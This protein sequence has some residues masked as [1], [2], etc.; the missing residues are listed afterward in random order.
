MSYFVESSSTAMS[1]PL[2]STIFRGGVRENLDKLK[3]NRVD[4]YCSNGMLSM[5]TGGLMPC[6]I[7]DFRGVGVG[8]VNGVNVRSKS[9]SAKRSKTKTTWKPTGKVFT[10]IGYHGNLQDGLSL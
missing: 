6:G 2:L 1:L 8:I 7:T 10:D 9:K 5:I 3:L 4:V